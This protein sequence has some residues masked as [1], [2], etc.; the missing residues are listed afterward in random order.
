MGERSPR[1]SIAVFDVGGVLLDW[2]PRYLYRKLF[3][4]A[5]EMEVFLAEI[6][7]PAWNL[8]MDAGRTF[9]DGVADLTSRFPD[10][11][12]LIRAYDE[13]W[14]EMVPGA[15]ESTVAVL[16]ELK[17][18]GRPVYAVTNFSSQKFA[19]EVERWPFLRWFDGIVVSGDE[20]I[21]KP[22]PAIFSRLCARYTLDPQDCVMIDDVAANVEAARAAGLAGIV[23]RGTVAL[24]AELTDMGLLQAAP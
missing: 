5:A 8:T 1:A 20:G 24:R 18:T 9:A 4:D 19:G 13:R 22:N 12:D 2:N 15:I 6:C 14:Q 10:K 17:E 3:D 23:Y 21:V 16:A 11:A 7:S